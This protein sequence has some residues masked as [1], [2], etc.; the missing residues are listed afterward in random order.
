MP[1]TNNY[2][3]ILLGLTQLSNVFQNVGLRLDLDVVDEPNP[4]NGGHP[5]KMYQA[6]AVCIE[7]WD[8][9][10]KSPE[11]NYHLVDAVLTG[12]HWL[13]SGVPSNYDTRRL[14]YDQERGTMVSVAWEAAREA[15]KEGKK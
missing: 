6:R 4:P 11:L 2:E 15:R 1:T 10:W 13:C 8:T 3:N 7:T 14:R 5:E 9:V 12:Y